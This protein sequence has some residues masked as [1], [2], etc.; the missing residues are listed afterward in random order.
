MADASAPL[1]H[2][3]SLL[4]HENV[5]VVVDTCRNFETFA[6]EATIMIHVSPSADF[7]PAE[8]VRALAEADCTRSLVNPVSVRT[9]WGQIIEAH[10][11][12]LEAL[13]PLCAPYTTVSFHASN[14]MLLA[15]LP[16]MGGMGLALYEE[17]EVSANAVWRQAREWFRTG[18]EVQRLMAALDCPRAIGS[19]IEGASYPFAMLA[20]LAARFRADPA[21]L[22]RLPRVAEELVFPLWA[23]NHL[24]APGGPPYV[25]FRKALSPL[26]ASWL[27]PRALRTTTLGRGFI[28]LV[29]LVHSRL[30]FSNDA[31]T[32]TDAVIAGQPLS[33]YGWALGMPPA[34][35]ARYYGI[36]RVA[37]RF[38][39]PLRVAIRAHTEA[40]LQRRK[41]SV[42]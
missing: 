18:D 19:Q 29:H 37:R 8:L 3:I 39:D 22:G 28:Q 35:P 12:N 15:E 1:R 4:V 32:E 33:Q 42:Q 2:A 40:V 13:A 5:P 9:Q 21:L 30:D 31:P 34:P 27:V 20:E 7:A 11:A 10:F 41:E 26:V 16:P 23:A 17:R 38:D 25:R 36:K 6:R 14:D 24:H